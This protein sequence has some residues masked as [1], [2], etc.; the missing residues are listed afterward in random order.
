MQRR[1]RR[2][3]VAPLVAGAALVLLLE[4]WLW[5]DLAGLAAAISRRL[6]LAWLEARIRGLP[7]WAAVTL[8]G[9]PTLLVFPVKLVALWLVARGHPAIGFATLVLAKIGGTALLARLYALT[10][11]QLLSIAWFARVRAR[12]LDFK[13][14][15]HEAIRAAAVYRALRARALQLRA[16]AAG[17]LGRGEA[18][19]WRRWWSAARRRSRRR[20]RL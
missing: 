5:N 1:L 14:R 12:V 20:S 18:G 9:S 8:F 4:E 7:P 19:A 6:P 13:E 11:P 3:L 15:V 10:E 17:W 2:W 16:A